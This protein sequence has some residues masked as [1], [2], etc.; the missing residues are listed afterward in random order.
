MADNIT[1]HLE[2]GVNGNREVV[3]IHKGVELDKDGTGYIIFS[4]GQ[5]LAF[6]KV[7]D[8]AANT[9]SDVQPHGWVTPIA[10]GIKA[11]CGGPGMCRDCNAEVEQLEKANAETALAQANTLPPAKVEVASAGEERFSPRL[12]ELI[13]K[14]ND[15]LFDCG[16]W[17]DGDD[18]SYEDVFAAHEAAYTELADYLC[19]MEAS[20]AKRQ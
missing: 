11:R 5:A 3:V 20:R 12:R 13:R 1:G 17:R 14:S 4:K 7:V 8:K 16:D 19:A 10:G 18:E 15:T 9:I 2:V 6:S